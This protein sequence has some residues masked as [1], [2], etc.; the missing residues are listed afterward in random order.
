[1]AE[2][3]LHLTAAQRRQLRKQLQHP[4]RARPYRRALAILEVGGGRP[5]AAV[6]DLLGVTRQS[7][8]N[9]VAAYGR[10]PGPQALAD[11][12]GVGRPSRWT[13]QLQALLQAAVRLPPGDLGY[14]AMNWTVPLLRDYLG[15][16]GGQQLSDD[17]I[18]RQLDRLGY[19]WKRFRYLLPADPERDKKT[20]DPLAAGAAAGR[21]RQA[22]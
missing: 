9:W 8:Y 22:V 3:P 21:Q 18:R 14:V 1:V 12:Y 20:P 5:I 19:V 11:R 13:E 16:V 10:S 15:R 6:A 7:V 17:T 4:D 2:I